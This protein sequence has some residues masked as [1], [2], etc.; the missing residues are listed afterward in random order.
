MPKHVP[1]ALRG[2]GFDLRCE[3]QNIADAL[4]V[5]GLNGVEEMLAYKNKLDE[6]DPN[7]LEGLAL[8]RLKAILRPEIQ[9]I[10]RNI[11]LRRADS[12][13]ATFD[14]MNELE[15]FDPFSLKGLVWRLMKTFNNTHY[16]L[17][18]M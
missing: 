15:E 9:D 5:N 1:L 10:S 8:K 12:F 13:K 18:N 7:S 4:V 17:E 3:I 11:V 14:Y 16:W 6:L 2:V